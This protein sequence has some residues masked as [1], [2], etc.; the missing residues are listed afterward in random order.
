MPVSIA[1][2]AAR[3]P[4]RSTGMQPVPTKNMADYRK[5]AAIP[6]LHYGD[7]TLDKLLRV[8]LALGYAVWPRGEALD[9]DG[10]R[11]AVSAGAR[12]GPAA[13][14]IESGIVQS[15]SGSLNSVISSELDPF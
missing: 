10:V 1:A 11:D 13:R 8:A 15:R 5:I 12:A 2:W 3:P 7:V 14:V 4:D 6:N 9:E